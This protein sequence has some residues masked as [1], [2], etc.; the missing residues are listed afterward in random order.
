MGAEHGPYFWA[1]VAL[2]LSICRHLDE[3][4]PVRVRFVPAAVDEPRVVAP[5]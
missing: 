3:F 2:I 4:G 5:T 1:Y